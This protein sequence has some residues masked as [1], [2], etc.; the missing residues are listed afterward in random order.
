MSTYK[1][2]A[3]NLAE[4][5]KGYS[6]RLTV[7]CA[8]MALG[9]LTSCTAQTPTAFRSS[10]QSPTS[11]PIGLS[12][13]RDRNNFRDEQQAAPRPNN[14][15]IDP[16]CEKGPAVDLSRWFVGL[17]RS[18]LTSSAI[19]SRFAAHGAVWLNQPS[20]AHTFSSLCC[21]TGITDGSDVPWRP[22][23]KSGTGCWWVSQMKTVEHLHEVRPRTDWRD[24]DLISDVLP[25]GRLC[26]DEL[27]AVRN[28]IS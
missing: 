19:S 7:G 25:F 10:K 13:I 17:Q 24:I 15:P 18:S 21:R 27:N 20:E 2:S 26:Y 5:K 8:V 23:E 4:S 9:I 16:W 28:A 6:L 1:E 14:S 11:L 12:E 3:A 22:P